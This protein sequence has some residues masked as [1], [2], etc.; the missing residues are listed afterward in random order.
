MNDSNAPRVDG[1]PEE[2]PAGERWL[3]RLV[4]PLPC[5]A[6]EH[7]IEYEDELDYNGGGPPPSYAVQCGYCGASGPF[8][9]GMRRD[10]HDGGKNDAIT[11]WNAMPRRPNDRDQPTRA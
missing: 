5:P 4:R 11:K 8:G 2:G 7:A 1:A 3:G 10:D 6:C 9:Y